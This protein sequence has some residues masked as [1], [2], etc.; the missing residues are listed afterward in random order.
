VGRLGT[1]ARAVVGVVLLAFGIIAGGYWITWW[2]LILG[3][4]VIPTAAAT[5]AQLTR[6]AF[7]D[8]ALRQTN[9]VASCVNCAILVVLLWFSPTR[10]ATLVFL[11]ASLLVAAIRGYGGCETLAIPNWLLHRDD[12]VGCYVFL[13]VD[14]LEA[15]RESQST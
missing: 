7:A 4:V 10:S 13:P 1:T 12:Q 14:N 8:G 15:R 11:G 6:L 5:A 3:I 2:H 9:H